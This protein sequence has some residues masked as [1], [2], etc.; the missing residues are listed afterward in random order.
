MHVLHGGGPV[1]DVSPL[2]ISDLKQIGLFI[3]SGSLQKTEGR[4]LAPGLAVRGPEATWLRLHC[5]TGSGGGADAITMGVVS[6]AIGPR[7]LRGQE[8]LFA[9]CVGEVGGG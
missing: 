8:G 4:L 9:S 6:S 1:V 3:I 7:G 5:R 2:P